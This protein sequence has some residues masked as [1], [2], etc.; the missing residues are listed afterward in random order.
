MKGGYFDHRT[1]DKWILIF[2][3]INFT[4]MNLVER[5]NIASV[6]VKVHCL[7]SR[8]KEKERRFQIYAVYHDHRN[9]N[10]VFKRTVHALQ[11]PIT[12]VL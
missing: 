6:S 7:L 5:P 3:Q 12:S 9:K 2:V 11:R 8:L 10:S 1:K 4:N